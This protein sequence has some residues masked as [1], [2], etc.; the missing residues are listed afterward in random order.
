[1]T[2]VEFC[3]TYHADAVK[4]EQTSG[5]PAV[6]TLAQA[7]L[8]SGWGQHAPGN[9]FFGIKAG[10][11]WNGQVQ[12]LKTREKENGVSKYIMA[13]FRKY[14]TPAD[15]F[16]DHGEMISFRFPWCMGNKDPYRFAELLQSQP[17]KYATDS[18]YI[19]SIKSVI[20]RVKA[21]I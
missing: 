10:K 14:S 8:E 4:S 19:A 2:P 17:R 11:S 1:M 20:N 18:D 6:F 16:K 12:F 21:S 13:P 15:C 7:A 9:N 3:K 5:V